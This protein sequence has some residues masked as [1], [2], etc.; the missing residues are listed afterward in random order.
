MVVTGFGHLWV[1]DPATGTPL[2]KAKTCTGV[3]DARRL[4]PQ[5][6]MVVCQSQVDIVGLPGGERRVLHHFA[7]DAAVRS[8]V[9]T[10]NHLYTTSAKSVRRMRLSDFEVDLEVSLPDV[11]DEIVVSDG[12]VVARSGPATFVLGGNGPQVFSTDLKRLLRLSHDGKTLLAVHDAGDLVWVSLTTGDIVARHGEAVDVDN[13]V[14]GESDANGLLAAYVEHGTWQVAS[15]TTKTATVTWAELGG[16]RNARTVGHVDDDV[17]CVARQQLHCTSRA[18]PPMSTW[19]SRLPPVLTETEAEPP[20]DVRLEWAAIVTNGLAV[21]AGVGLGMASMV[22][23]LLHADIDVGEAAFIA[24]AGIP[25]LL[26]LAASATAGV[27]GGITLILGVIALVEAEE[28]RSTQAL[29]SA[30]SMC[31]D[32]FADCLDGLAFVFLA[33]AAGAAV[34]LVPTVVAGPFLYG[35]ALVGADNLVGSSP[36]SP[37]TAGTAA[38]VG[39]TVTGIGAALLVGQLP[40]EPWAAAAFGLGAASLG[41]TTAYSLTRGI[42]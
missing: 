36:S 30:Q 35:G 10:S 4:R 14:A 12:G 32:L 6:W 39:A 5:V 34:V 15:T 9:T 16:R 41:G 1:V 8:A 26:T 37:W 13:V 31:N 25:G 18:V 27:V 11:V 28:L 33:V 17:L 21:G 20:A 2:Q 38:V 29:C 40:V 22:P 23:L 42:E 7:V 3:V 19:A 24:A